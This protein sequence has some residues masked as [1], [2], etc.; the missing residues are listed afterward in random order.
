MGL[1]ASQVV[2]P[3]AAAQRLHESRLPPNLVYAEHLQIRF[4][5]KRS[6]T[7][8]KSGL[9]S[10]SGAHYSKTAQNDGSVALQREDSDRPRA[11]NA[12]RLD[13]GHKRTRKKSEPAEVS[14]V[15]DRVPFMYLIHV[16]IEP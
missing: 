14:N 15:G 3:D 16:L 5:L 7:E 8:Q 12:A 1:I 4:D 9:T 13:T 2:T 6:L 11:A 10:Y